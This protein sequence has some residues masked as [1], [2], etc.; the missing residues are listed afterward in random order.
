MIDR[1]S[2]PEIRHI[3]S[4][5]NRFETM[6]EVELAYLEALEEDGIAPK[7]GADYIRSHV[8]IDPSRI[9]EL[10]ATLR[11][12]VIA[13]LVHI[14]EQAGEA[15]RFLHFGLTSSDVLDTT[16]ALQLKAATALILSRLWE[17]AGAL[18]GLAER[19][20]HTRMIGRTHGVHAEV[21]TFGLVVSS[22]RE[23][24]LR[25]ISRLERALS[26]VLVGKFSGAVGTLAFGDP[27]RETRVLERLGLSVEPVATQVV[28]RDRHAFYFATLAVIGGVLEHIALN[29]RHLHRTEVGEVKEGFRGGQQGSSAMP[30][31]QNPIDSENICGQARLL[32]AYAIAALENVALWHERDISHSSVERMIG[33]DAT[34]TLEF[35]TMR[36]T[37][38][39]RGLVVD[40]ERM[41]KN[42]DMSGGVI[43]SEAVLLALIQSGLSRQEAYKHVQRAAMSKWGTFKQN[44]LSDPVVLERLGEEGV[45][46]CLSG[47]EGLRH[48]EAIWSRRTKAVKEGR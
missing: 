3:W 14:S 6:L 34:A 37:E 2:T 43:H 36:L 17:L 12:E 7:G 40:P 47:A 5:Q 20:K 32:R 9:E 24:V 21:T 25:S 38:V 8:H 30:H 22:W 15:A 48:L 16:F 33:P 29:I 39:V 46:R 45:E 27:Q 28:A 31:K 42:L 23:A 19:H 35:A 13:F 4:K 44:L 1:Y 10:E 18:E 41:L 11:H 26:D